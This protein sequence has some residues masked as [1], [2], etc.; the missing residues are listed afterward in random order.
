VEDGGVRRIVE[1][2]GGW[3][4]PRRLPSIPN[5]IGARENDIAHRGSSN[6]VFGVAC[7]SR[8][9]WPCLSPARSPARPPRHREAQS[10]G[11][12]P[13]LYGAPQRFAASSWA[14]EV[15]SPCAGRRLHLLAPVQV[16][17]PP[18]RRSRAT[19]S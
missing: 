10:F 19:R 13:G 6:V 17:P 11:A 3:S 15:P 7:T 18:S 9:P 16:N 8:T 1:E 2:V 5:V 12:Q 4:P 14:V